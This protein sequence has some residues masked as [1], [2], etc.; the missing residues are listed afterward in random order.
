MNTGEKRLTAASLKR[1][2]AVTMLIDHIGAILIGYRNDFPYDTHTLRYA[3]YIA[4]RLIGKASFPIFAFLLTEGFI[5]THSLKKYL[6]RIWIFAIISEIPFNLCLGGSL[7]FPERQ[8]I[9]F[10]FGISLILLELLSELE[11]KREGIFR[12]SLIRWIYM[13][14][15]IAAGSVIAEAFRFDYGWEGPVMVSLVYLARK[16]YFPLLE[17][18]KGKSSQYFYYFFYPVHLLILYF[19][20]VIFLHG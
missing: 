11:K 2:A 15:L 5:H 20:R 13:I 4:C 9:L 6:V 7:S 17:L 3:F 8:N 18:E 14:M 10:S 16:K 12:I 19:I 1:I